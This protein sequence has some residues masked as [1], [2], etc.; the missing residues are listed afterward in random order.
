[1]RGWFILPRQYLYYGMSMSCRGHDEKVNF[2]FI[3]LNQHLSAIIS[4]EGETS[5]PFY[6]PTVHRDLL[7]FS[8]TDT[9]HFSCTYP[10]HPPTL[11]LGWLSLRDTTHLFA[12]PN[13]CCHNSAANTFQSHLKFWEALNF[14]LVMFATN[15]SSLCRQGSCPGNWLPAFLW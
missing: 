12:C 14:G 10:E 6:R 9:L 2:P 15:R 11:Y 13:H 8:L 7:C 3:A 1:M 4:L 5:V